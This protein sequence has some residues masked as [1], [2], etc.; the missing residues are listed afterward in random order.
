VFKKDNFKLTSVYN[1]KSFISCPAQL[2]FFIIKTPS[3]LL[4]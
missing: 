2:S 1:A 4:P 3:F